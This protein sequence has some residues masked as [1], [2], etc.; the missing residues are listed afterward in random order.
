M[1]M[2]QSVRGRLLASTLGESID[3]AAEGIHLSFAVVLPSHVAEF[4]EKP[5]IFL[6]YLIPL[7]TWDM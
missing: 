4:V 5:S 7:K 6:L 3:D 1:V 2:E